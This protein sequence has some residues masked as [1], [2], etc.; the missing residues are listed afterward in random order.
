MT[1]NAILAKLAAGSERFGLEARDFPATFSSILL[2]PRFRASRHVVLLLFPPGSSEPTH[3]AKIPRLAGDTTGIE[4]EHALL[5]ATQAARESGYA[6]IPR[7]VAYEE[8]HDRAILV[9]SALVGLP[10]TP[11]RV[12]RNPST[13]IDSVLSWLAELPSAEPGA[14]DDRYTR[15][16][17]EPLR[18]F[19]SV[20]GGG[21]AQL[22]GRT[23]ELLEPLRGAS[24]PTVVEHGDLSHP[25]LL[26][27]GTGDIGVVDWELGE[28]HGL[29]AHDLFFFLNYVAAARSRASTPNARLRVFHDA[30]IQPTGWAREIVTRYAE[31][32]DVDRR[33]LTPLLVA[34]WS[35]YTAGLLERLLGSPGARTRPDGEA[36]SARDYSPASA[37]V[38]RLLRSDRHYALWSHTVAHAKESTWADA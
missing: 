9:E 13:S 12:R 4:R 7:V 24:L 22:V 20:L 29:P 18:R 37:D 33:Y 30:V 26:I 11:E 19:G 5:T 21:E 6:T 23:L 1:A 27:L 17:E 2:T 36:P 3:V 10:L 14:G 31:R 34:C 28:S 25:N 32:M 8:A 35:R 38:A 15:L 16:L